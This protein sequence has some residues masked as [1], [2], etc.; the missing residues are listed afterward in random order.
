MWVGPVVLPEPPAAAT[1]RLVDATLRGAGTRVALTIVRASA[2]PLRAALTAASRI[3]DLLAGDLLALDA[4]VHWFRGAAEITAS[5]PSRLLYSQ[6]SSDTYLVIGG[7][8]SP[9]TAEVS[10]DV[11]T[12]APAVRDPVTGAVEKLPLPPRTP[13]APRRLPVHLAGRPLVLDF[14]YGLGTRSSAAEVR[15]SALP[16][17]GEIIAR[18]QQAQAAQDAALV[19]YLA[20]L[21]IEQHF[22]PTAADPAYNLVF[23]NDLFFDHQGV[24]WAQSSLSINGA[25]WR[26]NPPSIPLLQPEKV[27]SLPLELRLNQD[28]RYRLAGVEPVGGR[29]AFVVRF[30]PADTSRALYRGTVWIDRATFVRLKVAAVEMHSSGVVSANEEEQVFTPVG[31]IGGQ[32][33]WLATH[34]TSRQTF[35]VAGRTILNEREMRLTD[36]RVNAAD[37]EGRRAEARAGDRVMYRDTERGVRYLVKKGTTRVVSDTLTTSAKALALGADID[38]SI[39]VPLPIAGIDILDFNFLHRDMQLALLFGGV[40]AIG[41]VQRAGLWGGRFDASVDFFGL[42]VKGT[43][44]VFDA[45]S[46]RVGERVRTLPASTGVNLGYR[47]S[48]SHKLSARYEVSF[49]GYSRDPKT[50][51]D[52][53]LPSSTVTTGEGGGYEY[54]RHGYS[55]AANGAAYRRKTWA[56]WGDLP[57]FD[58]ST[59]TY[60]RY[61]LGLSKDFVF[62]TFHTVHLNGQYFGGARLD[63]FSRYQFGLFDA[64]RM[65]GV[66]SAVR[67]DELAM[68][69]GSYSF[70]L[71]D[72]YRLDLFLD[73][74]IGRNADLDDRW[75]PV[76]GTG[77]GVNFRGPHG[78]I[79]RGDLGRSILPSVYRGVGSTVLQIMIL[80]PL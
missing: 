49:Q 32:A 60:T 54:R 33:I 67:F 50:S 42:A 80:K 23:E 13:N 63:R 30:D 2:A 53:T 6:A 37:F 16:D 45:T 70:N 66:P 9:A 10:V 51:P 79:I 8:T 76:T 27:L 31:E 57:A 43:D 44:P 26:G 4:P 36:V 1:E 40:I 11:S 73:Q 72:Q 68:F 69:R 5:V 62:A 71:F 77:V 29:D 75:R 34:L 64:T 47:L 58:P 21:R 78:T 14:N 19:N 15:Q 56:P 41:N 7:V 52:F 61:D 46:E 55:F 39:D 59:R 65:H 20:H 28:Y 18:H 24:E 74:A 17:V 35:L 3:G 12:D 22:H 38:P 48:S 25:T